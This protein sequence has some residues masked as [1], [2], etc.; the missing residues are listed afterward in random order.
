MRWYVPNGVLVIGFMAVL[1]FGQTTLA[2]SFRGADNEVEIDVKD[3]NEKEAI[4]K[5]VDQVSKP[6][7]K[8]KK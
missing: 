2:M 6:K 4:K 8:E 5:V 1:C 3:L 7:N